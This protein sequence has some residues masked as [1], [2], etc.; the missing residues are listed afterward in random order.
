ML[1]GVQSRL[2]ARL[3]FVTWCVSRLWEAVPTPP[4]GRPQPRALQIDD[5]SMLL[6]RGRRGWRRRWNSGDGADCGSMGGIPARGR[7]RRRGGLCIGWRHKRGRARQP[8]RIQVREQRHP[9]PASIARQPMGQ[10]TRY[11]PM[12]GSPLS[13]YHDRQ[14]SAWPILWNLHGGPPCS[15]C[16][17]DDRGDILPSRSRNREAISS[18]TYNHPDIGVDYAFGPVRAT[19]RSPAE[20]FLG[21]LKVGRSAIVENA[22]RPDM[23]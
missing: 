4:I 19:R 11:R 17:V 5:G 9:K 14:T 18:T 20:I 3:R 23:V 2:T 21:T 7:H 12:T 15:H 13:E 10:A 16:L 6:G 1:V 8:I 22:T